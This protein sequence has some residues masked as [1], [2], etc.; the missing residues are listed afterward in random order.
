MNVFH[1]TSL[2]SQ[3]SVSPHLLVPVYLS[4]R[5]TS[6][7]SPSFPSSTLMC[8]DSSSS[9]ARCLGVFLLIQWREPAP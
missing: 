1:P 4:C 7:P 9:A 5:H 6:S 2:F 3:P 8:C